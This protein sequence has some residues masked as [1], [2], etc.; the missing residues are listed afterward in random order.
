[1]EGKV[2]VLLAFA[3]GSNSEVQTD[4]QDKVNKSLSVAV[5]TI[6]RSINRMF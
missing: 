5:S 3:V 6:S 1:M 2:E 4:G